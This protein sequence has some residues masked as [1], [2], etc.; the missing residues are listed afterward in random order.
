MSKDHFIVVSSVAWPLNG[1][2]A[3]GDL[4]LIQRLPCLRW[5]NQVVVMLT[6]W[7]FIKRSR[8]VCIKARSPSV[9]LA[10]IGLVTG[11]ATKVFRMSYRVG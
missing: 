5:I 7:R 11:V 6:S 1:G 4:V 10:F 9:S 3:A 8:G 2:E